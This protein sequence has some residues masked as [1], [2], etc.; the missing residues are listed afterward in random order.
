[1]K[2]FGIILLLILFTVGGKSQDKHSLEQKK[3]AAIKELEIAKE[4]LNKTQDRKVNSLKQVAL[5]NRGIE[6]REGLIQSII[7]EIELIEAEMCQLELEI[8][9]L[10]RDIEQGKEEYS[11]IIYSI[12]INHTEE[13]KMMYLLASKNINEFYQRIKYMK[14]LKVY[15]EDKV[16]ELEGLKKTVKKRNAEL[17]LIREEKSDLLKEKESENRKLISER[18]ERSS[19]IRQLA[20]DE[21][22]I[23]KEIQQKERIRQE[24]ESEIRSIIE[25]EAKKRSSS[26]LL[27]SLTPEQKLV[28]TNFLSNKGRLPWPVARGVITAKF[29]IVNHPVL[30]GVKISNNGVDI[31]TSSR[32]KARAVYDGE[33]TSIFAILGANYTVIVMHGEYLSVYQNLIDLKVKVGDKVKAKQELGTVHSDVNEEMAIL[34]LQIWKSKEIL[35]PIDWLSR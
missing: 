20:Q 2:K 13:E 35:N 14:Y 22:K 12:F 11:R 21:R 3:Q 5:I 10:G 4:L 18:N 31:S 30:S 33:V 32:T 24:L 34:H 7:G 9:E 19:I 8:K 26:S 6:S 27:S 23:R 16:V 17:L 28:G 15:R 1:M 25:A 29:G